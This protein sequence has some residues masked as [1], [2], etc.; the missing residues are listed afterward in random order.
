MVFDLITYLKL[1]T[2]SKS[3]FPKRKSW[4]WAGSAVTAGVIPR[5]LIWCLS[6]TWVLFINSTLLADLLRI[7]FHLDMVQIVLEHMYAYAVC[8]QEDL[9]MCKHFAPPAL[10]VGED[11][12][13]SKTL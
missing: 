7:M 3:F 9:H 2:H 5:L 8:L 1:K 10:Q 13:I 6:H 4:S 12:I 11:I